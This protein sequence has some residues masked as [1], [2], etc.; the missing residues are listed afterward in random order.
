LEGGQIPLNSTSFEADYSYYLGRVDKI[1]ITSD[2]Q[3]KVIKGVSGVNPSA[4][5][6]PN[7]SMTL[8]TM[9][10]P[11]Y[12]FNTNDIKLEAVDNRRYTMRDIGKLEKRIQNLEYYT[13]LS[14]LEKDAADLTI[15]DGDGL[16][17]FKNG[18]VVDAFK[19]HS[20]GDVLNPDY[21]ASIDT[22]KNELRPMYFATHSGRIPYYASETTLSQRV[23]K[24][25]DLLTVPYTE[26]SFVS[27]PLASRRTV[28][29][30]FNKISWVG[31]MTLSPDRDDFYDI[32]RRPDVTVNI[33][34]DL[35]GWEAI[36]GSVGKQYT[37]EWGA[38]ETR[39]TGTELSSTGT[40]NRTAEERVSGGTIINTTTINREVYT[41][42]RNQT[43]S[44]LR[45]SIVPEMITESIGDRIID[46]TVVPFIRPQDISFSASGLKPNTRVYAFFDGIGVSA[47]IKPTGGSYGDPIVTD[48]T[49]AVSGTFNIPASTTVNDALQFR[50]GERMF[51]LIDDIQARQSVATTYSEGLF[52]ATGLNLTKETVY[53]STRQPVLKRESYTESRVVK[54]QS[55]KETVLGTSSTYVQSQDS[56]QHEGGG[57]HNDARDAA[58]SAAGGWG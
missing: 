49:G 1:V 3:F 28:V 25:G 48:S 9:N 12:T 45:S 52:V 11:A 39:W 16:E 30:P 17:R 37:T 55:V 57:H 54:T 56:N 27:Q 19:G 44:G 5:K 40:I 42:A 22:R 43:R 20:V 4:P 8:Y 36:A 46:V 15:V 14:L 21:Y 47:F 26:A 6:D 41:T 29:N 2:R 33:E 7:D 31:N 32:T 13:S 35:D 53:V 18:I 51:M 34:G 10:I 38:W 58:E 24:T 50:V 23:Q